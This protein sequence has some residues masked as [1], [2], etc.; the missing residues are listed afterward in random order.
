MYMRI[1]TACA[2]SKVLLRKNCGVVK[3]SSLNTNDEFKEKIC[4][5]IFFKRYAVAW[6]P[7]FI[8]C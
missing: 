4:R 6:L 1:F 8:M 5:L 3:S 2:I 7:N